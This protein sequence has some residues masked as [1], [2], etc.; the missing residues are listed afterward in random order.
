MS[1][2]WPSSSHSPLPAGKWEKEDCLISS[3]NTE[4]TLAGF[5]TEQQPAFETSILPLLQHTLPCSMDPKREQRFHWWW[6]SLPLE[7]RRAAMEPRL[8][9]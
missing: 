3:V 7:G 6:F 5:K 1:P 2:D 4:V 8:R 9:H